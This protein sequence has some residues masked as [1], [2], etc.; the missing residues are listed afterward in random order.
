M[1]ANLGQELLRRIGLTRTEPRLDYESNLSPE[2]Y[3]AAFD[4][5]Y[6]M[7]FVNSLGD[8]AIEFRS[9]VRETSKLEEE[10]NSSSFVGYARDLL[11]NNVF[12]SGSTKL[13]CNRKI[14][15][16]H[17]LKLVLR[18]YDVNVNY[19]GLISSSTLRSKYKVVLQE[20]RGPGHMQEFCYVVHFGD[21]C[22]AVTPWFPQRKHAENFAC[23][24][25]VRYKCFNDLRGVSTVDPSKDGAFS[26]LPELNVRALLP[27]GKSQKSKSEDVFDYSGLC[28]AIIF[29]E[30]MR[31][32]D[33]APK[34]VWA[35]LCVPWP[36][37][38]ICKAL[39][40]RSM[41]W[42]EFSAEFG[43]GCCEQD[44]RTVTGIIFDEARNKN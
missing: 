32:Y 25:C 17:G 35:I 29:R 11:D 19:I 23:M 6:N 16:V 20:P 42:D 43:I 38:Q 13:E 22:S 31:S 14:A 18:P 4:K 44:V 26:V 30:V 33:M 9:I 34:S 39:R 2:L 40:Y 5:A 7:L 10:A 36:L 3:A 28:R 41:E 1:S 15:L 8:C 12:C 27:I 24:L 37:A 21:G